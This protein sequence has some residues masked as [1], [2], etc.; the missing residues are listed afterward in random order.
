MTD[1]VISD[2]VQFV[3]ID[4]NR[5]G[6]RLD[7]FLIAV[8]KGVPK[9]RIYR[10]LRKG[11]VRVN[12]KRVKPEYRLANDDVVRIPPIRISEKVEAVASSGLLAAIESA[13]VF[14][15]DALMVVNKPSGIA[16]HGGSGISLGLIEALRQ[17]RPEQKFLELVHRLDR[18]T[19]GLIMVAKKR[20]M[21]VW[22][23]KQL[24]Q[25]GV[26][27]RYLALVEGQ[28]SKRKLKVDAPLEKNNLQS[29]ERMVR[30]SPSGKASLT[31]FQLIESLA[32]A[33]LIE[34]KPVTGRTHQIRVH[35]QYAGHAIAC[36][37]KYGSD[38]FAK[39][40][41]TKGLNRLFLH[42]WR[43]VITLPDG[44]QKTFEAPLDERLNGVVA[45]LRTTSK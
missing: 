1:K 37:P 18:D 43:L 7:N 40:M 35:T 41:K 26:D 20:S 22:L 36:D 16:V 29:G 8:L 11:E 4:D 34:A 19:S 6:Q 44:E 33:S 30:V 14:E 25:D 13:I 10:I 5:A 42:A 23:H 9:S 12:K 45:N 31:K 27:K 3:T 32:G 24:Q 15:S 28:W 21:L 38:E 39:F 2:A 17:L